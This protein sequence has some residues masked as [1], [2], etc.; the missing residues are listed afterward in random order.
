MVKPYKRRRS[1]ISKS[2][3]SPKS[4]YK[5]AR[6]HVRGRRASK[7]RTL[8]LRGVRLIPDRYMCKLRYISN[9]PTRLTGTLG[10]VKNIRFS[11]N[12]LFDPDVTGVGHQPYG[13]DQLASLYNSYRV[14][15]SSIRVT[16]SVTS[17][18]SSQG[19]LVTYVLPNPDNNVPVSILPAQEASR[20]R[21]RMTGTAFANSGMQRIKHYQSTRSIYGLSAMKAADADYSADVTA[22]P[23]K[24][25]YWNVG[26]GPLD[27]SS[28]HFC[29]AVVQV[30]YYCVFYRRKEVDVS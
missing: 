10:G 11:G 24:M 30:T 13:F 23:A 26:C 17:T 21:W 19:T 27:E 25:W 8:L 4:Y 28:D 1:A 15:G 20:S 7:P 14:F 18:S 12:S 29:E 22:N 5:P 2:S 6:K 16:F 3:K 9:E